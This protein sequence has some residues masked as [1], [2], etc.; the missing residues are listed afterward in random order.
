VSTFHPELE[1]TAVLEKTYRPGEVEAKH[2]ARWERE[3][4][5]AAGR[6]PS[7]P[8]FTIVIPPPNV[9]GSL[10][11]GHALNNTLQ[12]VLVRYKRMKGFDALWMPGTDHA[13]IATQMVVERQLAAEGIFL[14]RGAAQT[15]PN[16]KL[17]DRAVF[18]ER[19]WQW[20]AESG[21][22]ITRQLR[23][24][25]ASLDWSRERFTMD[26]G[27]SAAV[28]K[29]FVDLYR[30]KLIYKDKRLVNWDPKFLTAI[31]DLEVEARETKGNLW[32]IN[33]PV[34]GTDQ[35]ITVATTRPE[36]MLGDTGVAVHPTDERWKSLVGKN[37]IL[38][39]VGRKIPIVADEYSDPEKGTGAV[40]ITPAHD[41]NDFEVGKRHNLAAI[42]VFTPEARINDNA[43]DAYRGLDRFEARKRVLADLEAL[44]LLV[45]TEPHMHQVPHGDRSGVPIEPY[46]TEQWYVDAKTL[47][48]P[49]IKAVE[50]GRTT[51]VPKQWEKTYFHWMTNIEPWCVSRQLWWGHQIPAW[52]G[53]DNSVFVATSEDEARAEARAKYGKDVALTRD[54]DVLDTWF[55]SALWAFSTLGWP[56]QTP[57]LERHYPTDVLVTGFDIIFFWVAR[58]MMMSLHF[59][60]DVP[61]RTVYVHALV[62][63]EKGQ[64]MSKSKGNVIDPLNLIDKFGADAL[65]FTLTAMAAQGRDIKLAESRVEGYRN[66]ATKVWNAARFCEMNGCR[67]D[68]SFEPGKASNVVNRWIVS[69]LAD[70][71]GEVERAI[72]S[73]RYNEA[74][75]AIY[76]FVWGTYCD[77]Y[78]EFAKPLFQADDG[79]VVAETRA[80]AA[81]ALSQILHLLHPFMPFITEELWE[82]LTEG[83]GAPL[84]VAE[85]PKSDPS[86]Q[87]ADAAAE[88]DWVVK[89]I[90]A[91]RATRAELNVSPGAELPLYLKDADATAEARVAAHGALIKR[92]ARLA[93][94][95]PLTGAVPKGAVQIVVGGATAVLPLAGV[96]DVARERARL[97]K[98]DAKL[99]AE[100]IK[101]E[102]KLGNADFVAKAPE[103]VVVEN[104][105]RLDDLAAQRAKLKDALS[106]L[107]TM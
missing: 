5:F 32:H 36:T 29:V 51:F 101:I 76:Q 33:Y 98:D 64:K 1:V 45:K 34:E 86:W 79:N 12:D 6:D 16:E 58:M 56:T 37:V 67:L 73:Y 46:L 62:R 59:M 25:G 24:L 17:I 8:P 105:E 104:R 100:A 54:P 20:K 7:R 13:G 66:F 43:P 47:A 93:S 38:P 18:L 99:A 75:G 74:A 77:W 11:M 55:S 70:A 95:D 80:T 87:A 103:E 97:E 82:H 48:Q 96:V 2:Y 61:F 107:A 60:K 52:Y 106:R 21:G 91:V 4:L 90:D 50:D 3:G 63:D 102:K 69:R 19:V 30:E 44:G 9:T 57:E 88:M 72:E 15:K 40:K 31:S 89:A 41:F 85:W 81:W 94:I 10:H 84:I 14:K 65:R 53:P 92:L 35:F 83:K 68:P 22:T 39:L 28:L 26:E 42:N 78:L 71:I 23:R 49:A 27:L